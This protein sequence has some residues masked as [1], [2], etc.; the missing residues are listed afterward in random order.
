MPLNLIKKYPELLDI[1]SLS[2]RGRITSLKRI[3]KRDIED[4]SEFCFR[5][6]VIR[7]IAKEDGKTSM[8]T[9][10]HH[11][12]TRKMIDEKGK[13]L[14][15]RIFDIHRSQ[16]LHWIK[17][18]TEEKKQDKVNIFSC[19]ER[20][21]GK[22]RIRTYIYDIE[23]SYVIILEPQRKGL[24][25]YLLTAYYINEESEKQNI[26]KKSKRKLSEVI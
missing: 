20:I 4:N 26:K 18:H 25:Y 14:K 22:D 12:I 6:K 9:L 24:D 17:F 7:P 11:L 1:V 5:T 2:E 8:D 16:R 19:K 13:K 21:D 23:E 10:F 3:F 15:T